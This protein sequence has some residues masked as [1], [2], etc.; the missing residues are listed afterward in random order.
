MGGDRVCVG[1]LE[2]GS[3]ASVRLLGSD[4]QN[5]P[6]DHRIRPGDIWE[7][8][9]SPRAVT[10][11]P[12]SEDVVVNAGRM[13]G[14]VDMADMKAAILDLREAWDGELDEIFDGRLAVTDS[15]KA[16]LRDERPPLGYST[17]FWSARK[18]LRQSKFEESGRGYWIPDGTLIRKV[19]Y[20]GMDDPIAL[21]PKGALIRFSLARWKAFPPVE[22]RC[23]LQLSGWYL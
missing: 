12:H 10:R 1:G 16:F 6:E 18:A 11:A 23:Y 7:I 4:Q 8:T 20:V 14:E 2:S 21:V 19:K 5:L 15:G 22:A 17:G 3:G 9:C 13:V